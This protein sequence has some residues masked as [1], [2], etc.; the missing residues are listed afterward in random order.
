MKYEV[1]RDF[2]DLRDNG[3]EYK[4]GD[5][6]PHNGEVDE[7]R[8]EQLITPTTQRG[9]LITKK[10]ETKFVAKKKKISE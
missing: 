9:P 5:I 3:H 2:K 10:A 8:V 7:K 4:K 6:Y 1:V